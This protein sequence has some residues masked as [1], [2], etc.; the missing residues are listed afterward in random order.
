MIA[1]SEEI[2][3]KHIKKI[4]TLLAM[5]C[6]TTAFADSAS[7][8]W[9]TWDN[10]GQ[11]ITIPANGKLS[12]NN[13]PFSAAGYVGANFTASYPAGDN[14]TVI[15]SVPFKSTC[16]GQPPVFGF[17]AS[18]TTSSPSL[19]SFCSANSSGCHFYLIAQAATPAS[20]SFEIHNS[21]S[22]NALTITLSPSF[23][24]KRK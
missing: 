4:F 3:K 12:V 7:V 11:S 1:E 22:Q 18:S 15:F 9:S 6:V 21:S 17:G 8:S 14:S 10:S 16:V 5:T 24:A 19:T 20:C 13:L 23:D 2:M